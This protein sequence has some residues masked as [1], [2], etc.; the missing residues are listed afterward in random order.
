MYGK[1]FKDWILFLKKRK[2]YSTFILH[3]RAANIG[4]R[5]WLREEPSFK[6][7]NEA[8]YIIPN[9]SD[10]LSFETFL[11]NIHALEWHVPLVNWSA[12]ANKFGK[13]YGYV[14]ERSNNHNCYD[15]YC[16]DTYPEPKHT[17]KPSGRRKINEN[18]KK[19]YD[20]FYEDSKKYRY[21]R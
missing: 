5:T 1:L 9:K 13:L 4:C 16:I 2:L 10:S 14:I 19:W 7:L 18:N 3:Y 21:R 20:R 17:Y 11:S 12:L 8:D 6:L 15:L